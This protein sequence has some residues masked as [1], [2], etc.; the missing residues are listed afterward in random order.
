MLY[1][2]HISSIEGIL[3]LKYEYF[4]HVSL[5]R[6]LKIEHKCVLQVMLIK[7]VSRGYRVGKSFFHLLESFASG[8]GL[9]SLRTNNSPSAAL[10]FHLTKNLFPPKRKFFLFIIHIIKFLFVINLKSKNFSL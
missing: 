9:G 8:M 10:F 4:L 2:L 1:K 5:L 6:F 7:A 3:I